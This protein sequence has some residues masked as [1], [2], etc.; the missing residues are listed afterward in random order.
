MSIVLSPQFEVFPRPYFSSVSLLETE[1]ELPFVGY[2]PITLS[3]FNFTGFGNY[4]NQSFFTDQKSN[5]TQEHPI[6]NAHDPREIITG[7]IEFIST[8]F[9]Q[10]EL[11][12]KWTQYFQE[13]EEKDFCE[14]SFF[15]LDQ[16]EWKEYSQQ[17]KLDHIVKRRSRLDPDLEQEIF[18]YLDKVEMK[19]LDETENETPQTEN[20]SMIIK[21]FTSSFDSWDKIMEEPIFNKD[22]QI[23]SFDI[24]ESV[25]DSSLPTSFD[26]HWDIDDDEI[27]NPLLA[28]LE[29]IDDEP[30]SRNHRRSFFGS[31]FRGKSKISNKRASTGT[32]KQLRDE[33]PRRSLEEQELARARRKSVTATFQ[34]QVHV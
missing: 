14:P 1:D 3:Q 4:Q 13:E 11:D 23:N 22:F 19:T 33:G 20:D 31:L 16:P 21:K 8:Q 32:M 2:Q 24:P 26:D 29:Y 25:N 30:I 34:S 7:L 9:N 6:D 5:F 10:H 27:D 12:H 17:P 15:I 28:D 18:A